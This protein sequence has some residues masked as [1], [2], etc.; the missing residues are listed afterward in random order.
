MTLAASRVVVQGETP[1]AHE[2]EAIEF[3]VQTLPNSDPYHLWALLELL[4]PTSGRL[5]EI[6][7]LVIGYSA[8]YVIEVK[9]G[10]GRYEG[11]TLDWYRTA[12]GEDCPRYL[13]NPFRLTNTK[14]K[15]LASRL[16]TKMRNPKDA[17]FVQPLVFLSA[18][19]VELRFKNYGDN[20]VVTRE[21]FRGAV[22]AG[23]FP[24][25]DEKQR[26]RINAP[27]MR[28]I[29][30]AISAIGLRPRKGTAFV[31]GYELGSVLVEGSGYQDR[32]ATHRDRKSMTRRVRI[33]TVPQASSIER[34]Q[35]LRRAA[36]REAQLLFDVREHP[37]ILRITDYVTDAELGPTVMFDAFE[38]AIP[39]DAFLRKEDLDFFAR[40][41]IVQQIARALAYCHKKRVLH[42]ALSPEAVLVRRHPE[43]RTIEVRLFNFQ[44]GVGADVEATTHWSQLASEPWA[45]Y[46]APELREDPTNRSPASDMFS[47]GALAYLVFTGRAPGVSAREVDERLSKSSNLDPRVVDDGLQEKIADLVAGATERS[48]VVRLDDAEFWIEELLADI[49]RPDPVEPQGPELDPLEARVGESLGDQLIVE[50]TADG[51]T[52][53]GQG[54][55][56]RVLQVH[57]LSDQRSY[58]LKVSSSPEHD[59]RL[60]QEADALGRLRHPRIVQLVERYTFKERP[61]LLLS[62]AGAEP[63]HRYL[64]RE[65][66]V[67]LELAARYGEDL[68]SVLEYLEEQKILHRDIK[69][70]NIG[71]GS[72][73]N[74]A[75]HLT[76]FD[77]SL[78]AC[79]ATDLQVGTAAY[80]DPFLR[81]R[82]S[83]DYA[84]ERWSA[85][86]TLHE[87]LTGIRPSF[88]RPVIDPEAALVLAVER[89]DAS[90][91]ENL[92]AFF[93]RAFEK[94]TE[95]RFASTE[96]MRRVWNQ[97][98]EAAPISSDL[99]PEVIAEPPALTELALAAIAPET[100]VEALPLSA[101]ARNALDRAG[102]LTA[103][104]LLGLADNR[105]SAI[106]G[107]GRTVAQ[108]I[109]GFKRQ[110]A[111][112]RQDAVIEA[113]AF[114][115]GYRGE[116][117][118]LKAASLPEAMSKALQDAGLT[119]LGAVAVASLEQVRALA[120]R[121][122]FDE[123][124]LRERLARENAD[125]NER[126]R[127]STL[128]GWI[129]ALL[130][131]T[132]KALKHPR[133]LYGLE[134][135]F[136]GRLDV[137]VSEVA[138]VNGIT[139]AAVY[140]AIAKA[141]DGWAEY[142]ALPELR[143]HAHLVVDQ[144]GGA[145]PLPQAAQALLAL[146]PCRGT[147]PGPESAAASAALVRIVVEVEKDEEGG[148]RTLRLADDALWLCASDGHARGVRALG[149]AADELATRPLV[150]GPAEVAR[151]LAE[152]ALGTPLAALAIERLADLAASASTLAARS[153]RL[154][155]YPRSMEPE[156]AL[157]LCAS[158]LKSGLT[159]AEI[160]RRVSLRYPAAKPLP[161]RP[162]LDEL[163]L[164]HGL[165]FDDATSSYKRK[166]EGEHTMMSSRVSSVFRV[167]TALPNQAL[168]MEADA[169]AARQ[170]D[171]RLRNAFERRQ[172]RVLGVRADKARQA[173]LALGRRLD[174]APVAFDQRLVAAIREQMRLGGVKREDIVHAAD[175]AG[176]SGAAW[177]NLQNLVEKAAD[178]LA[179][180]L[181]PPREPLLLVQPGLIARYRL[182]GFLS[183]LLESA[184]AAEAPIV[185]LV[186]SRDTGGIPKINGEY[187]IPG[188]LASQVLWVSPDWIS[189]QH[190]RAA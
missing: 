105:L 101:R 45:I 97:A 50:E 161:P 176:Q 73:S 146:I 63:L 87:M 55:T 164:P 25:S 104:E 85:A 159:A 67:S 16:R 182:A 44:L 22:Q 82:G 124:A 59:E 123:P 92:G 121:H 162:P 165:V 17:P 51:R 52:S 9:S 42:G 68:L 76:L 188:L 47:L 38:G 58:A 157:A 20:G 118:A 113:K 122:S 60:A 21:T 139:A 64:A 178:A 173:A 80:R 72:S 183:R 32:S 148:L 7:L 40:V 145:M 98:F 57:R 179:A 5:H 26:P 29:A 11:D 134:Q 34:R 172:F 163:L 150:A 100:A 74:K 174:M 39:L 77:F 1:Y 15:I 24:G 158:Q 70:P 125:A 13:E 8:V 91:R 49:T 138:E 111:S 78:S 14:A 135:P 160:I 23:H 88:D 46:Q 28:D 65:G 147:T 129:D 136:L 94:D 180:V 86:V 170:F 127:P 90:V 151:V 184:R 12:P 140:I 177:R 56:S 175:L 2:R 119:T 19:D 31:G 186:P 144:A 189:N 128:E 95:N 54:A 141:R 69:P 10:P 171:E 166:G 81:L 156:R 152:V 71:V 169:V 168:S 143:R 106:R 187:A 115:P 181:L 190:N 137:A 109:L 103:R 62:L 110:W 96:E 43:T 35:Q 89:L 6:D 79:A 112:V 27:A 61:C 102:F 132:K 131:R 93:L 3:A 133:E 117:L 126:E 75:A 185:L 84:A 83:W 142:S 149:K 130:P 107:I 48:P 37:G 4:D 114:F 18:R 154:E 99:E 120:H 155:I 36:D 167:E 53:L 108:E 33:Y 153:A 116:D 66:T 30:Q 41:E